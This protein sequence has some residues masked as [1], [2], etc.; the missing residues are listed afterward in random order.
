[1]GLAVDRKAVTDGEIHAGTETLACSGRS[2]LGSRSF[3]VRAV[4]CPAA[5]DC[6]ATLVF[7]PEQRAD[8]MLFGPGLA[9]RLVTKSCSPDT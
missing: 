3:V 5:C 2:K 4:Q 8:A 9:P 6:T 1:V 7:S